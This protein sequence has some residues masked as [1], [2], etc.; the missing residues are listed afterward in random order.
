MECEF[1]EKTSIIQLAIDTMEQELPKELKALVKEI[2]A[3]FDSKEKVTNLFETEV[4]ENGSA[5]NSKEKVTN[6]DD[7][8]VPENGSADNSKE[9]VTNNDDPEVPESSKKEN[10]TKKDD[11]EFP[12]SPAKEN[13]TNKD[14]SE[15][16]ESPKKENGTNKDD[17]EVP[18]SPA[19]EN[20]TNKDDPEVQE[21]GTADNSTEK[22]TNQ[23]DPKI[24][25]NGLAD[26]S[27]DKV[28]NQDDPEVPESPDLKQKHTFL[29][30]FEKEANGELKFVQ[31]GPY[32]DVVDEEVDDLGRQLLGSRRKQSKLFK[33]LDFKSEIDWV[34]VDLEKMLKRMGS[35][36]KKM[37]KH[38]TLDNVQ[39]SDTS[40]TFWEKVFQ[41]AP[42]VEE[43]EIGMD[44]NFE[45]LPYILSNLNV[46]KKLKILNVFIKIQELEIEEKKSI[47]QW[48]IQDAMKQE[49]P[50]ELEASV[51]E[52]LASFVSKE[53][54]TN[55]DDPE[56]PKSLDLK[57]IQHKVL[58]LIEKE[59][60]K[61]PQFVQL[62]QYY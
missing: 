60:D 56:V 3:S 27:K 39:K 42:K 46:F 12:T 1:E 8:E 52:I 50:K 16:S 58:I 25:E 47:I 55:K 10:G 4:P 54:A 33:Y 38:L 40:S 21:N 36:G 23:D 34:N 14:D 18:E 48:A 2:L 45:D 31:L 44:G 17:S 7:P 29:I 28:T 9:K 11:P 6:K 59:A 51:K 20:G 13:G 57:Q 26:N 5:D 32:Y 19:K 62:G 15:V 43:I 53:E 30:S 22:V 24:P 61:E 49:L 41:V 35:R 37:I